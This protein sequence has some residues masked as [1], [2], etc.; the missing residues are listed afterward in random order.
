MGD[1]KFGFD[2]FPIVLKSS[3]QEYFSNNYINKGSCQ[4]LLS[5]LFRSGGGLSPLSAKGFLAKWFSIKGVGG[6][7]PL[8]EKIR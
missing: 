3:Y 8:T 4:K 6:G 1:L 2:T 7:A 5:G